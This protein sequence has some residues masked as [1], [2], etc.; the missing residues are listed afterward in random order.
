MT[1]D[2]LKSLLL[3]S[4]GIKIAITSMTM[5]TDDIGYCGPFWSTTCM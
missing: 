1:D 2:R 3:S 5:M 4:P